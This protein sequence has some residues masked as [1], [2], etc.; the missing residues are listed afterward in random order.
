MRKKTARTKKTEQNEMKCMRRR[1]RR[2]LC[3]IA[4]ITHLFSRCIYTK[5][6]NYLLLCVR[7]E[8][9]LTHTLSIKN[10]KLVYYAIQARAHVAMRR[11][12]D[13]CDFARAAA[14]ET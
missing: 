10:S 3:S 13:D 9:T 12:D 11:G 7:R 2:I 8:N 14:R 6:L 5:V 1:R 4:D